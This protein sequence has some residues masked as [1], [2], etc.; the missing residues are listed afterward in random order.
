M[1]ASSTWSWGWELPVGA[2]VCVGTIALGPLSRLPLWVSAQQSMLSCPAE[3]KSVSLPLPSP[4]PTCC[5]LSKPN[6]R[7]T[8]DRGKDHLPTCP[9]SQLEKEELK[10]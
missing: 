2:D 5:S 1:P 3:L 10:T 9:S 8:K 4:T 7:Q 6:Q